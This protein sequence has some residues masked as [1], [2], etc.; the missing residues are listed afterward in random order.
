MLA[1]ECMNEHAETEPIRS[2]PFYVRVPDAEQD[3]LVTFDRTN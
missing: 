2:G 1:G 3:N